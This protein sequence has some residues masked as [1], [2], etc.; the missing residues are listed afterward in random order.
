MNYCFQRKE[1]YLQIFT[2]KYLMNYLKKNDYG[3]LKFLVHSRGLEANFRQLKD[4]LDFLESIRKR[5]T[6]MEGARYKQEA[7]NRYLT[8]IRIGNKS[9]KQQKPCLILISFSTEEMML[10]NL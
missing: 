10:S 5:E 7:F 3:Y 6:S 1:N 8:K 4:S 9:E 2:T